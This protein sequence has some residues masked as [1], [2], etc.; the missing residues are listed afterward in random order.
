MLTPDPVVSVIIANFNGEKF[1]ADALASARAQ[2]LRNIEIIVIDDAS[3]D[4]SMEIANKF[5]CE[6]DR[7]HVIARRVRSGPGGAR[8]AGLAVAIRV[9]TSAWAKVSLGSMARYS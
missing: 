3:S 2:T 4:A 7:I 1:L 6:D 8:N 5:A 9:A